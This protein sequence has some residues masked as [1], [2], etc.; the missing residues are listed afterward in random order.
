MNRLTLLCGSISESAL[1]KAK[2]LS[3]A[4]NIKK[5]GTIPLEIL[6]RSL[7]EDPKEL[8]T[9]VY[10]MVMN[11]EIHAR[12]EIVDGRLYIIPIEL[13]EEQKLKKEKLD[14]IELKERL[15]DSTQDQ[16]SDEQKSDSEEEEVEKVEDESKSSENE[17]ESDPEE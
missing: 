10:E 1:R 3:L 14:P 13:D 17:R 12:L 6:A 5:V 11:D 4:Q 9:L 7:K 8:E 15:F 2:R 16:T